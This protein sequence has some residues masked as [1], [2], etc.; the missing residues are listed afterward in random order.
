RSLPTPLPGADA[1]LSV[2]VRS[3]NLSLGTELQQVGVD[4]V[5]GD[6][7][8]GLGHV[9][10]HAFDNGVDGSCPV[11]HGPQNCS[12]TFATVGEVLV[13][14]GHRVGDEVAVARRDRSDA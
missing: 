10:I 1:P 3:L 7:V 12:L 2:K 13:D 8:Q 9:D 4:R 14:L 6:W 11:S 5:A